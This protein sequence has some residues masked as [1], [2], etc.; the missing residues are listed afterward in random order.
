MSG[1]LVLCRHG[2][3]EWNRLGKFTGQHDPDLT[4]LGEEE[5]KR[6][7]GICKRL[8]LEFEA[9]Y[10][11]KLKRARR[12]LELILQEMQIFD[13]QPVFEQSLNERDYGDLSGITRDEARERWGKEQVRLWRRSYE[14]APPNG[15]S[16]KDTRE[17]VLAYFEPVIF[18][19]VMLG[20][21][22]LFVSHSN[23]LRS[24]I[25]KLEKLTPEQVLVR[26]V[27]TGSAFLYKFGAAGELVG[28]SEMK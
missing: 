1:Y 8:G 24:V 7:G 21:T 23:V 28:I 18:H 26:E 15:E 10:S 27:G 14:A 4:A 3:S 22:V 25:M 5:A 11:S 9:A 13:L 6:V 16:L 2:E 19:N 12:T 20:K 17:R